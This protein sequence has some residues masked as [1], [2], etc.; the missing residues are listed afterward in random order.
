MFA[1]K[2]HGAWLLH[3]ASAPLPLKVCALFSSAAALLGGAGQANYSAAN[4]CL[5]V[6]ACA[7]RSAGQAGVS[8]QW[9]PWAEVG[10][11]S[12]DAVSARMKASGF[13]LIGASAG[14]AVLHSAMQAYSPPIVAMLPVSWRR[15]LGNGAV[16]SLLSEFAPRSEAGVKAASGG[17]GGSTGCASVGVS[18]DAVLE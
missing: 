15:L 7:R 9:G 3:S 12:G 1:P 13:G 10:M 17:G 2:A 16:P 4:S 6:S 11:A 8:M 14:L 18:L 5:D